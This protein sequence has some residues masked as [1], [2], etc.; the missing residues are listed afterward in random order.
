MS[1]HAYD[2]TYRCYKIFRSTVC[3]RTLPLTFDI[4][5]YTVFEQATEI[6]SQTFLGLESSPTHAS[7]V[8]SIS[9]AQYLMN[10]KSLQNPSIL[11]HGLL[12]R[13]TKFTFRERRAEIRQHHVCPLIYVIQSTMQ[14]FDCNSPRLSHASLSTQH[15]L[16]CRPMLV[17]LT[18]VKFFFPT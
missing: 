17:G 13:R 10:D 6:P 18:N 14:K 8:F 11:R 5:N 2:F 1:S 9:Q 4:S 16:L 12:A 3:G 15:G 7:Y